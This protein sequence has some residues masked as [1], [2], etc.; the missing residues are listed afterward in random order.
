MQESGEIFE[1]KS[2]YED[3]RKLLGKNKSLK[4]TKLDFSADVI[5]FDDSEMEPS[6]I[7]I[8]SEEP[9]NDEDKPSNAQEMAEQAYKQT[10]HKIVH[11]VP[12][13]VKR[14]PKFNMSMIKVRKDLD[15]LH[16]MYHKEIYDFMKWAEIEPTSLEM[17]IR[18]DLF[19]RI[20]YQVLQ[21]FP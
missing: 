21:V 18:T 2:N 11:F 6:H 7:S 1:Y 5:E 3:L 4:E 19:A 10:L 12:A 14:D 17:Q 8:K 15:L 13:W 9:K 16:E 20:K